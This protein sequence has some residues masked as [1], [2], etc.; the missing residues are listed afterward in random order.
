MLAVLITP[1]PTRG[2]V[3][4]KDLGM[5]YPVICNQ[6]VGGS[7][8]FASLPEHQAPQG[9][10]ALRIFPLVLRCVPNVS[11]KAAKDGEIG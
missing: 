4:M 6:Q 5:S 3:K 11:R 10:S 2:Y 1:H 9:F 8:P 7:S